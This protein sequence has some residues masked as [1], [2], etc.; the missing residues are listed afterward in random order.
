MYTPSGSNNP[1]VIVAHAGCIAGEVHDPSFQSANR[2][3][4]PDNQT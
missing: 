1:Q 4:G 2:K 3:E